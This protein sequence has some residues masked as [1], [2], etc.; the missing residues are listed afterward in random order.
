MRVRASYALRALC[1]R[2]CTCVHLHTCT[3]IRVRVC[4]CVRT[5][6]CVRAYVCVC[7]CAYVRAHLHTRALV[8]ACVPAPLGVR[9][10]PAERAPRVTRG[11]TR[12][13]YVRVRARA[14]TRVRARRAYVGVPG[15]KRKCRS[16][17]NDQ[18]CVCGFFTLYSCVHPCDLKS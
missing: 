3:C 1:V 7:T 11:R 12:V 4:V 16:Y 6:T 13:S 18:K 15:E 2:V 17:H 5:R 9:A 14:Y 10:Y 8:L